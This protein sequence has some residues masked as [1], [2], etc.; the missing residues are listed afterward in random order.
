MTKKRTI[1]ALIVTLIMFCNSVQPAYA[2]S[3][4]DT[5]TKATNT[6]IQELHNIGVDL[7]KSNKSNLEKSMTDKQ[8]YDLLTDLDGM[9][10]GTITYSNKTMTISSY[11]TEILGL[12]GYSKA[13]DSKY[14]DVNHYLSPIN[15]AVEI[16]L[17]KKYEYTTKSKLLRADAIILFR[18][19]L[20]L[21]RMGNGQNLKYMVTGNTKY[22][23]NTCGE[24]NDWR[25]AGVF[26]EDFNPD[27]ELQEL[28]KLESDDSYST[29][30]LN[31]NEMLF[32]TYQ[33]AYDST[34]SVNKLWQNGQEPSYANDPKSL[35]EISH[36]TSS[37]QYKVTVN[38]WRDT[39]KSDML[40]NF[41]INS[42]FE[43]F[44]FLTGDREVAYALFSWIDDEV[45]HGY[46]D[47]KNFGFKDI[48]VNGKSGTIEMNG[49]KI[50]FKNTKDHNSY[51]FM[52]ATNSD[53]SPKSAESMGKAK[54]YKL[55]SK[56]RDE[57]SDTESVYYKIKTTVNDSYYYFRSRTNSPNDYVKYELLDET[58]LNTIANFSTDKDE[59]KMY[60]KLNPN[61]TYYLVAGDS[62]EDSVEYILD[63]NEVK[64][65]F[66][67]SLEGAR[68]EKSV[69]INK[70]YTKYLQTSED[71]DYIKFTTGADDDYMI[72]T[73]IWEEKDLD[74][75]LFDENG[76]QVAYEQMPIRHMYMEVKLQPNTTYYLKVNFNGYSSVD[77]EYDFSIVSSDAVKLNKSSV[78]LV[79]GKTC[80][81]Q[82]TSKIPAD[83]VDYITWFPRNYGVAKTN[84][85]RINCI[86]TDMVTVTALKKGKTTIDCTYVLKDGS[87]IIITCDVTVK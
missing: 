24:G 38:Y 2:V 5:K 84:Y 75:T 65:D 77:F 60:I 4:T 21:D 69:D 85:D 9:K 12:L 71:V 50:V 58:G 31:L 76:N 27:C 46:K 8:A 81:L 43:T 86:S 79:K 32:W 73:S 3:V 53:V 82:L 45:I 34:G 63:I 68:N 64:D 66:A 17:I 13:D 41:D 10:T 18:R 33:F 42:V 29:N 16:G 47:P 49:I 83:S 30:L 20:E 59:G 87:N 35:A 74:F 78:T 7:D 25:E 54:D 22:W 70:V 14:I 57:K 56:I 61:T 15:K 28:V 19:A 36:V 23:I 55:N 62:N 39:Y 26:Y 52:N 80:L 1:F 72:H 48:D 37:D 44:Y 51:Y 67:D 11:L 40:L 6:A